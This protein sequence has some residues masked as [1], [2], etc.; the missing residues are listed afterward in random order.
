M[1]SVLPSQLRAGADNVDMPKAFWRVISFIQRAVDNMI[2]A[3]MTNAIYYRDES[4]TDS[5]RSGAGGSEADDDD[6]QL[7]TDEMGVDTD[8]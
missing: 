3:G 2:S 5:S 8:A 4:S 6:D 7:G 1:H